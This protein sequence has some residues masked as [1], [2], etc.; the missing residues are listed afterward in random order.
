MAGSG[1]IQHPSGKYAR[2]SLTV[3]S[4]RPFLRPQKGNKKLNEVSYVSVP[5]PSC[6][7]F[8]GAA[9]RQCCCSIAVID[10]VMGRLALLQ[11]YF[12]LL[13]SS[14]V[15]PAGGMTSVLAGAL[16]DLRDVR[17]RLSGLAGQKEADP[18]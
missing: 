4:S 13:N 8:R 7:P 15:S 3:L 16:S 10:D 2:R 12:S 11:G 9:L 6:F 18:V 14:P 5:S 17:N 1:L